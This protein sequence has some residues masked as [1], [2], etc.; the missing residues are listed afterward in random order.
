M[1]KASIVITILMALIACN[2]S[3]SNNKPDK[4]QRDTVPVIGVYVSA[5]SANDTARE[6]KYG[7][8]KRVVADSFMYFDVDTITRK[9][10]WGKDTGYIITY[11]LP[12]DS[13][14]S[15]KNKNIPILDSLGKKILYPFDVHTDKKFVRSGWENVD[16]AASQLKRQK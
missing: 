1:K 11:Y 4:P 14:I 3:P 2:N 5:L 13:A 7:Q 12:I 10:K 6:I 15:K 9:R 8:M 16:S